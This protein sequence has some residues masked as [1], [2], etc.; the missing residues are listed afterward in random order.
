MRENDRRRKKKRKKSDRS[1]HWINEA[2]IIDISLLELCCCFFFTKKT[3]TKTKQNQKQQQHQSQVD[4]F[5]L[6][7]NIMCA[8]H[9]QIKLVLAPI[10]LSVILFRSLSLSLTLSVSFLYPISCGD[11]HRLK[12]IIHTHFYR[13]RS[14]SPSST[15]YVIGVCSIIIINRRTIA[16]TTSVWHYIDL[17]SIS[18]QY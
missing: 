12:Q 14:L 15:L 18:C 13:S 2:N 5:Q 10:F 9:M 7:F 6:L 8:V 11:K 1:R 4:T 16:L 17:L 3:Q